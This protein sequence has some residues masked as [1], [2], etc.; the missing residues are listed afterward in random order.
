M[1]LA[2][3]IPGM[4]VQRNACQDVLF[5]LSHGTKKRLLTV[6]FHGLRVL[7]HSHLQTVATIS[8]ERE[9]ALDL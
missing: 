4:L 7:T 8:E 1:T 3:E 5:F 6:I 2:R 9:E